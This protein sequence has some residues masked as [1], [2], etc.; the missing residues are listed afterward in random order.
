MPGMIGHDHRHPRAPNNNH[1]ST[2]THPITARRCNSFTGTHI[3]VMII[4]ISDKFALVKASLSTKDP[5]HQ[6]PRRSTPRQV[7]T[8]QEFVSCNHTLTMD[9]IKG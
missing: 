6:G 4:L 1:S 7:V 8:S 5:V 9:V 2:R 3:I